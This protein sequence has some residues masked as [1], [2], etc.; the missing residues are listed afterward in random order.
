MAGRPKRFDPELALESAM[1]LFWEKGYASTSMSELLTRMGICRQSLY[2]TYGDKHKLYLAALDL[3]CNRR[4]R[5]L[6]GELVEPN[7]SLPQIK[8]VFDRM[9]ERAECGAR[10]PC[11][12]GL[13]SMERGQEDF[14]VSDRVK[15]QFSVVEGLFVKALENAIQKGELNAIKDSRPVARH[16]VNTLQ[17][18]GVLIKGGAEPEHARDVV[19]VALSVLV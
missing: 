3:Y 1:D 16:L 12:L 8:A 7:A 10:R 6:V 13:S 2:D 4:A 14:D 17:G 5:E 18:L 19:N 9:I 11:M 15:R